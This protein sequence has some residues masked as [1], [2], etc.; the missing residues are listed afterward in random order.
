MVNI[1]NPLATRTHTDQ[2]FRRVNPNLKLDATVYCLLHK[3]YSIKTKQW[4]LVNNSI[5]ADRKT[6]LLFTMEQTPVILFRYSNSVYRFMASNALCCNKTRKC[7]SLF[8]G[9]AGNAFVYCLKTK[10]ATFHC[11]SL[12][13]E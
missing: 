2:A 1:L 13:A 11:V 6:F 7:A 4:D 12:L 3:I 9:F 5:F 10:H 8:Y